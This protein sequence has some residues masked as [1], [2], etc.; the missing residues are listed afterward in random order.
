MTHDR[1][2]IFQIQSPCPLAT[3]LEGDGPR[4]Y[5]ETCQRQVHDLSAM[6]RRSALRLRRRFQRRDERLCGIIR[7]HPDGRLHFQPGLRERLAGH[8]RA[9]PALAAL[10]APGGCPD[11]APPAQTA[12]QTTEQPAAEQTAEQTLTGEETVEL[13][14]ALGGYL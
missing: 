14:Q 4:R 3:A 2:R 1:D 7:Q 12:E 11:D 8:L 9:L 13:L 6:T 10:L 5:C